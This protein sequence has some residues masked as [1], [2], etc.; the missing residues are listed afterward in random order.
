MYEMPVMITLNKIKAHSPCGDY[1]VLA[2]HVKNKYG[3][4]FT[5]DT[6]FPMIDGLE[7]R[8][9]K[10]EHS[11]FSNLLWMMECLPEKDMLWRGYALWCGRSVEHLTTDIRVKQC[12]DTVESFIKGIASKGDL[13]AA[14]DAAW[15]AARDAGDAAWAAAKDARDAAG[16]AAW[17]ARSAARSAAGAAAWAAAWAAQLKKL[18]EILS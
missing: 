16:A 6:E 3:K 11:K 5:N 15:A 18:I 14:R 12:L 17:D 13:N 8:D 4:G 2:R 10:Y 1:A 7:V 9:S